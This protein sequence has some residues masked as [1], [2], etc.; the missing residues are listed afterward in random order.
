MVFIMSNFAKIKDI[1]H[2]AIQRITS[3]YAEIDWLFG[4]TKFSNGVTHWGMPFGKIT[5]I[6]GES[7]TGKSRLCIDIAKRL[8]TG[9][10][11]LYFP[12]EASLSDFRSWI[13][14][15][16]YNSDNF[17]CSDETTVAGQLNVIKQIQPLV[18]FIDS[19]NEVEDFGSGAKRNVKELINAYR[20]VGKNSP[21]HII[22]LGQLN[23]DGSIKGSTTLP[24]LVDIA[25]IVQAS[26]PG[27][28]DYFV[29][30]IGIKHRYGRRGK[31]LMSFWKHEEFGVECA[32]DYRLEDPIWCETHGIP[33]TPI[34]GFKTED[35]SQ[36]SNV[37]PKKGTL[38]NLFFGR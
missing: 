19:I 6:S 20:T 18:V 15:S 24:H 33:V 38:R 31:Q 25:L 12:A 1:K 4:Y 26:M 27:D 8:S 5:L 10:K 16:N 21:C 17:Y 34:G 23:Q 36:I 11:V 2:E 37:A 14:G 29:V 7:G 35:V 3:G 30:K 28:T 22:L 13:K 32:S 9:C